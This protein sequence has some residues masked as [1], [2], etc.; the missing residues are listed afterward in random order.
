MSS[1]LLDDEA[2]THPFRTLVSAQNLM[3]HALWY[4]NAFSLQRALSQTQT[5]LEA[6]SINQ[7]PPQ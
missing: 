5:K 6:S 3:L 7:T 1:D 4:A 2:V